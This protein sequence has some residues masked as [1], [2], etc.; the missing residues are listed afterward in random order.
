[1]V[2]SELIPITFQESGLYGAREADLK[3]GLLG[4]PLYLSG[5]VPWTYTETE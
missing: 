5:A 1:M 4:L 2:G 3:N